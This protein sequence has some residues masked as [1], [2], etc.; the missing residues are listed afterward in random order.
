MCNNDKNGLTFDRQGEKMDRSR[1]GNFSNI[2]RS[3]SID[4]Q[5]IT[6]DMGRQDLKI[7]G[8]GHHNLS[9][10]PWV[11]INCWLGLDTHIFK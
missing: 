7:G 2:V 4:L 6:A 3:T 8:I 1:H 5:N 10:A 9:T 11:T